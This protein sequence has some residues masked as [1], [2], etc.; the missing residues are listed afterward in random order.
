MLLA[1]LLLPTAAAKSTAI[2]TLMTGSGGQIKLTADIFMVIKR[3][4]AGNPLMLGVGNASGSGSR[5]STLSVFAFKEYLTP[6]ELDLFS[7]NVVRVALTCFNLLPERSAAIITWLNQQNTSIF[8][9]VATGFGPM[10]LIFQRDLL[11]D[12]QFYTSVVLT[13]SGTPGVAPWTNDCTR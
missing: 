1:A 12:G 7:K 8:K 9:K 6:D 13:R 3:T 2:R 10:T 11:S 5:I 4:S